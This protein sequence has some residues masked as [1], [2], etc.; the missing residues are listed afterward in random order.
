MISHY[1]LTSALATQRQE[2]VRAAA[3]RHTRLRRIGRDPRGR[4]RP[5]S[6]R[7]WV[8]VLTSRAQARVS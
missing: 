3:G 5:E 7:S 2:E 1:A 6:H 4:P 8:R